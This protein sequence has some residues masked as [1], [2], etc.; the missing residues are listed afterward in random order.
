MERRKP[1]RG[2]SPKK[3][4][5]KR[6]VTA[7]TGKRKISVSRVGGLKSSLKK[8]DNNKKDGKRT[9]VLNMETTEEAANE[10]MKGEQIVLQPNIL[11][12]E[13]GILKPT[14]VRRNGARPPLPHDSTS[15]KTKEH[16][17][18]SIQS[19]DES[20][21]TAD[22][23]SVCS[24]IDSEVADLSSNFNQN[25]FL[26]KTISESTETHSTDAVEI[27][28]TKN[29]FIVEDVIRECEEK[30][31][32]ELQTLNNLLEKREQYH[33]QEVESLN[34]TISEL[35]SKTKEL[36]EALEDR[37]KH[38]D[39]L[40]ALE[41]IGEVVSEMKKYQN[42]S[43]KI[44]KLE[45]RKYKKESE[46]NSRSIAQMK[47]NL[48]SVEVENRTRSAEYEKELQTLNQCVQRS[49]DDNSNPEVLRQQI[50]KM[51]NLHV[52]ERNQWADRET[53]FMNLIK[54][55]C[56][57]Q[58]DPL[59]VSN[60]GDGVK[61]MQRSHSSGPIG[62]FHPLNNFINSNSAVTRRSS[63]NYYLNSNNI[64]PHQPVT[65]S[66]SNLSSRQVID[67]DDFF[68]GAE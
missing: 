39:D 60:S 9:V 47:E 54:Q 21:A 16:S 26:M 23:S 35:R 13:E 3:S 58:R 44:H 6:D 48:S 66:V 59:F 64:R 61:T 18:R 46:F 15:R 42:D 25:G 34:S 10:I 37:E 36:E 53:T 27:I 55:S 38:I 40:Q 11:Q 52:E 65:R 4:P 30:H 12:S 8:K 7:K 14:V 50:V 28:E 62:H 56:T 1:S 63:Q 51:S 41:G 49:K 19:E 31:Q 43:E 32:L 24:P 17:M 20:V 67:V 29:N 57:N 5:R 68:G 22:D 2:V 33:Q 45:C